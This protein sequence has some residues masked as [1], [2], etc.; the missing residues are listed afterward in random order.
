VAVILS[1]LSNILG[2]IPAYLAWGIL[3]YIIGVIEVTANIPYASVDLPGMRIW[4]MFFYYLLL[5][6]FLYYY[7][8]KETENR[9]LE[10]VDPSNAN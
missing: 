3:S 10:T 4:M 1:F 8:K 7:Y 5:G 6:L 9:K 2:L